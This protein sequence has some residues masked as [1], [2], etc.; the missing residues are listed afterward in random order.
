VT[1]PH[2]QRLFPLAEL[3]AG[4]MRA[5]PVAGGEILVCHTAEG[6]YALENS[7]THACTRLDEGRLR[8]TRL[9][10]PLHAAVF[11]VASGRALAGPATAALRTFP[12]RVVDGTVEV[13]T[14][15]GG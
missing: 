10:C 2:W 6:L 12:V 7:C 9:S 15:A 5:A 8:G 4:R 14:G 1:A 13:A 11:D 3:A